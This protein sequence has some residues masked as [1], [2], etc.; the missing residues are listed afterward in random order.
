[1]DGGGAPISKV[2]TPILLGVVYFV[3]YADRLAASL[4]PVPWASIHNGGYWVST[5]MR[6][7]R[8][9]HGAPILIGGYA[10]ASSP[11]LMSELWA[12]MKVRK[13]WWFS[14]SS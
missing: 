2:T 10:M 12:F 11:G 7:N 8:R 13:K 1:M 5:R 14:R 3:A 9:A 6:A 4:R